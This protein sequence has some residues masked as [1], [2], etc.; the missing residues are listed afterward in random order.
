MTR[1]SILGSQ[2]TLLLPDS[3]MPKRRA[4]PFTPPDLPVVPSG[5]RKN[6]Y[7]PAGNRA[8]SSDLIAGMFMFCL[9]KAFPTVLSSAPTHVLNKSCRRYDRHKSIIR[10]STMRCELIIGEQWES[11]YYA[12]KQLPFH[13]HSFLSATKTFPLH[14]NPCTMDSLYRKDH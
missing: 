11:S 3:R 4:Q 13:A 14:L 5:S 2:S 7:Y 6:A 10:L 9:L 1:V 8:S 12:F